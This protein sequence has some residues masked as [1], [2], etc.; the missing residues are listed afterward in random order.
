VKRAEKREKKR[1]GQSTKEFEI[2]FRVL[3]NSA[4][5]LSIRGK[6]DEFVSVTRSPF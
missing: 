2:T 4:T 6:G 5:N 3:R 1:M